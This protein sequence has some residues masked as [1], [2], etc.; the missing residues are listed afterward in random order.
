MQSF[1]VFT[2]FAVWFANRVPLEDVSTGPS[3]VRCML[4]KQV[5]PRQVL[6]KSQALFGDMSNKLHSEFKCF[7]L[8]QQFSGITVLDKVREK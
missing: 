1:S 4:E 5:C 3:I 6:R 7:P 8:A 2:W